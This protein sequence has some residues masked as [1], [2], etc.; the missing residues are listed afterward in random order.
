MLMSCS[1]KSFVVRSVN[2]KMHSKVAVVLKSLNLKMSCLLDPIQ[3]QKCTKSQN[4]LVKKRIKNKM[5]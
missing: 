4:V 3:N 5:P 1:C 2:S